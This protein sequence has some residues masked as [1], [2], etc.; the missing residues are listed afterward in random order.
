MSGPCAKQVV[1]A[2]LV[3]P[4]GRRYYG[5][6][7][8]EAPQASCPRGNMPSGEGYH[9]CREVCRQKGHAEVRAILAAGED[10]IGATIYLQGHVAACPSCRAFAET[11]RVK[12][13][14]VAPPPLSLELYAV[15]AELT[16]MLERTYS[17]TFPPEKARP[18]LAGVILAV[19]AVIAFGLMGVSLALLVVGDPFPALRRGLGAAT[20]F[21]AG[22]LFVWLVSRDYLT[23]RKGRKK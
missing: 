20:A 6:N 12:E 2:V 19:L 16:A 5:E 1:T 18:K 17:H 14:I 3:A 8:C 22:A 23:S 21:T 13:I 4:N 10:A 7:D 9:L 15:D 11:A